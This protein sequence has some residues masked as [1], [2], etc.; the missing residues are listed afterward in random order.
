MGLE[1]MGKGSWWTGPNS[2]WGGM[3][4]QTDPNKIQNM[5]GGSGVSQGLEKMGQ[6]GKDFL[7]P[8][9]GRNMAQ[10]KL[11][12]QGAMDMASLQGM[13]MGQQSSR[14]GMGGGI[15]QQ[16][17]KGAYG[18]LLDQ[19][20]Q[21]WQGGMQQNYGMGMGA[22]QSQLTGQQDIA[23]AGATQLSQNKA[24]QGQFLQ[25]MMGLMLGR[26]KPGGD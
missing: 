5:M 15:S 8:Y 7:D 23:A 10:F 25:S 3:T 21:N 11:G 6:L 9:S 13:Q 22:L 4:G 17:A 12:Q 1:G 16:Q 18:G 20:M 26:A 19:A 24:N 14:M 2:L